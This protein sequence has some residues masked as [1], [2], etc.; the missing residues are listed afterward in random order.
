MV[1]DS[2]RS[3]SCGRQIRRRL[4]PSTPRQ[5]F[6]LRM[7]LE[8][9]IKG[10]RTDCRVTA[11]LNL[12]SMRSGYLLL[13]SFL[14]VVPFGCC[15]EYCAPQGVVMSAVRATVY[16]AGTAKRLPD[17]CDDSFAEF[18]IELEYVAVQ[19]MRLGKGCSMLSHGEHECRMSGECSYTRLYCSCMHASCM[20]RRTEG[21][22]GGSREFHLQRRV[23]SL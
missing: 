19:N 4:S 6:V 3:S 1:I 17:I 11:G 15:Q 13:V 10:A 8:T 23:H 18:R 21:D 9:W 22:F 5:N 20:L 16:R 12:C 2:E 14:S 7:R